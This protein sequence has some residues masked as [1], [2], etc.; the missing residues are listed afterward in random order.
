MTIATIRTTKKTIEELKKLKIHPR[1]T[2][3]QLL[4]QLINEKKIQKKKTKPKT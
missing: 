2:M 4:R 1:Q 3:E